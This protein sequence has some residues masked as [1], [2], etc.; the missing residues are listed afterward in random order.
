LSS[1]S[2]QPRFHYLADPVCL[3]AAV[4]YCANRWLLK[5]GGCAGAL[6]HSYL[7]DL[8]CLPLFLPLILC[9][10][11]KLGIRR[12]DGPPAFL[13]V[14][15]NWI[16]FSVLYELVLPRMPGF[17][18]V[19][20]PWDVLAYLAGGAAAYLVWQRHRWNSAEPLPGGA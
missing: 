9:I 6:C 19:A 12:H 13:E 11:A 18:T 20:D 2:G 3:S 4:A 14:L 15:H 8:L 5:P 10:Q 16:V 7:N 1:A 17:Y